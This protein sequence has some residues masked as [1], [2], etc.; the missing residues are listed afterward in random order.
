[1]DKL[2]QFFT[3]N[4]NLPEILVE[5]RVVSISGLLFLSSMIYKTVEW[6]IGYDLSK[7]DANTAAVITAILGCLAAAWKFT[8]TFCKHRE[9]ETPEEK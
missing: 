9:K 7:L 4:K 5:Y 6:I 1:M 8:L 2:K 3:K